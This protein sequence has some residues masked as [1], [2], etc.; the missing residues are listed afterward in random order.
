MTKCNDGICYDTQNHHDH[1][2]ACSTACGATEWCG[3]GHCCAQ[4][5][6]YCGASCIDVLSDSSNCGGCGNACSGAT[7]YCSAG[8]CVKGCVPTGTRQPFD[9]LASST[10]SG[11]WQGNPCG[12]DTYSFA[13][14]NGANFQ[15][16]GEKV[17]CGG[18]TACVGHVGINTYDGSTTV[19]QGTWDVYCDGTKVGSIATTGKTCAG[20]A[21]TN[22]CSTS[23]TPMSCSNVTVQLAAGSGVILCCDTTGTTPDSMLVGVSAW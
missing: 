14:T 20:T 9:T 4:G 6:E 23:F 13:Q 22:G 7:P 12:S 3:S 19:C 15:A 1:C 2:G 5:T 18:T 8:A 17:V 11:C 10:A 16:V 21:M